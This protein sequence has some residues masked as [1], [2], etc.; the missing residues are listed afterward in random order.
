MLSTFHPFNRLPLDIRLCI[1]ESALRIPDRGG[2]LHYFSVR[3]GSVRG[4]GHFG[5]YRRRWLSDMDYN[6][7]ANALLHIRAR[8]RDA[9]PATQD[10][11]SVYL[12]DHGLWAAC[13]ESRH[14][15]ERLYTRNRQLTPHCR[16]ERRIYHNEYPVF[17]LMRAN[18][19]TS[20][21]MFQP[22][23]DVFCLG[24]DDLN[25]AL[26]RDWD[27]FGYLFLEP[28]DQDDM[29]GEELHLNL[30]M[31]FDPSWKLDW[32]TSPESLIEE[33]SPRGALVRLIEKTCVEM[34]H[35]SIW[36]IDREAV[37]REGDEEDDD[38]EEDDYDGEDDDYGDE[39]G[40]EDCDY[41]DEDCDYDDEDEDEEMPCS[42]APRGPIFHDME[43]EYIDLRSRSEALDFVRLLDDILYPMY[44]TW[45]RVSSD[46]SEDGSLSPAIR[47]ENHVHVVGC[48][49]YV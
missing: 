17:K 36:L 34:W 2:G 7:Q 47:L 46:Q 43:T 41:D 32:R 30:A 37:V 8:E 45:T 26:R 29:K 6:W 19:E 25:A 40:D 3:L 9:L 49:K 39:D 21:V 23:K 48:R 20:R 5:A 42:R 4:E 35:I 31:E 44:D 38:E 11:Q 16:P 12:W 33:E 28:A 22:Y 1:W 14:V 24:Y 15:I 10:D 27:P 18:H 13:R